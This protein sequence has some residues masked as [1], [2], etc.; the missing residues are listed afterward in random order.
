MFWIV[1]GILSFI[2]SS[3][4]IPPQLWNPSHWLA[5]NLV[6]FTV[7]FVGAMILTWFGERIVQFI[8]RRLAVRRSHRTAQLVQRS[9]PEQP[10]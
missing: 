9:Q 4:L 2:F 7:A 5:F 3:L 8:I 6:V 10:H 1:G